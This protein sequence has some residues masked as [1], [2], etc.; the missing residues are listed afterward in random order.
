MVEVG[1]DRVLDGAASREPGRLELLQIM[2]PLRPRR[3]PLAK[4][5]GTLDGEDVNEALPVGPA[6]GFAVQFGHGGC[7]GSPPYRRATLTGAV[8]ASP[9]SAAAPSV[10]ANT[11]CCR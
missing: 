3:C 5:G 7:H 8:C 10:R 9:R 2:A 11:A 1:A 6:G 4:I